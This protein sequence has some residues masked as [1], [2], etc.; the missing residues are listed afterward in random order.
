[1]PRASP[2]PQAC[3]G[4]LRAAR[5]LGRPD[6]ERAHPTPATAVE[7][8]VALGQDRPRWIHR[9]ALDSAPVTEADPIV[10]VP[11]D[12]QYRANGT[13]ERIIVDAIVMQEFGGPDVLRWQSVPDPTAERGWATVELKAAA[14][15]WHDVLV[16]QGKYSSPLPHILG[17][18]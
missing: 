12:V 16:R 2:M 3:T 14:L 15:N 9:F 13:T 4:A 11:R 18:D 1:M 10:T 7:S 5:Y 6:R 17:A 8:P